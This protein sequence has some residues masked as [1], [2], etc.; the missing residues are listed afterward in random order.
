MR[1]ILESEFEVNASQPGSIMRANCVASKL[2]GVYSRRV[3]QAY[4]KESIGGF[5]FRAVNDSNTSLEIDPTKID[6]KSAGG[7]TPE[8]QLKRNQDA[9]LAQAQEIFTRISSADMVKAMPREM[10][11]IAYFTAEYARQ[12]APDRI[13]PLV[14]GFVMLRIFNPSLLTPEAY[15]LLPNGLV[16]GPAARRNLT[17]ITKLLQNLSNNVEFGSKE[18]FMVPM[19]VFIERNRDRMTQYL[20][21]LARDPLTDDAAAA[22]RDCKSPPDKV[23]DA[24][25]LRLSD[26]QSIHQYFHQHADKLRDKI[27]AS[28]SANEFKRLLLALGAPSTKQAPKKAAAPA[29]GAASSSDANNGGGGGGDESCGV[30][31]VVLKAGELVR[32]DHA[33]R[34]GQFYFVLTPQLLYYFRARTDATPHRAVPLDDVAVVDL[35]D[36]GASASFTLTTTGKSHKLTAENGA[37]T[38]AWADAIND[39]VRKYS[40]R[41]A[42]LAPHVAIDPEAACATKGDVARAMLL[43]QRMTAM[44]EGLRVAWFGRLAGAESQ[45]RRPWFV[46]ECS[47]FGARWIVKHSYSEIADLLAALG[48]LFPRLAL[49][50]LPRIADGDAMSELI[51]KGKKIT[52]A[53]SETTQQLNIAITDANEPNEDLVYLIKFV[54]ATLDELRT[55]E[56]T[57]QSD[58]L[59]AF[60]DISSPLRAAESGNLSQLQFLVDNAANFNVRSD[61]GRAPM[62]IAVLK[63]RRDAVE[64]LALEAKADVNIADSGGNSPLHLAIY[65]NNPEIVALLLA[66]GARLNAFNVLE[67]S[68]LM[69]ACEGG[70]ES[71]VVRLLARGAKVNAADSRGQTPLHL[72]IKASSSSIAKL[73]LEHGAD[74]SPADKNGMTPLA[75]ATE[76]KLLD[77]AA[78]LVESG[79]CAPN[80]ADSKGRTAVHTAASRGQTRVLELL[81]QAKQPA[82]NF[83]ARDA[84]GNTPLHLA[85]AG[86]HEESLDVL[87]RSF[88]VDLDAVNNAGLTPLH[89]AAKRNAVAI[90]HKLV[91]AGASLDTVAPD[92]RTPLHAAALAGA[93]EVV[94]ALCRFDATAAPVA[95]DGKKRTPLHCAAFLG[96]VE[97]TRALAA[98]CAETI[99]MRD[100]QGNTPLMLACWAKRVD[101]ARLLVSLGANV[102][103]TDLSEGQTVLHICA[104]SGSVEL[105]TELLAVKDANMNAPRK[106][107]GFTPLHFACALEQEATVR[108]L[109]KAKADINVQDARKNTPLHIAV[110]KQ[111][112]RIALLLAANGAF[113]LTQNADGKTPVALCKPRFKVALE[114][115]AQRYANRKPGRPAAGTVVDEPLSPRSN[116]VTSDVTAAFGF[117]D[118]S[119]SSPAPAAAATVLP[120]VSAA[121]AREKSTRAV[122]TTPSVAAVAIDDL[123]ESMRDTPPLASTASS[124][125]RASP[126]L[127]TSSEGESKVETPRNAPVI[128]RIAKLPCTLVG[129]SGDERTVECD[130]SGV[131]TIGDLCS[132]IRAAFALDEATSWHLAYVDNDGDEVILPELDADGLTEVTEFAKQLKVHTD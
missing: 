63:Q 16:P 47:A 80:V 61:T 116:T 13:V 130:F 83:G 111:F 69:A 131:E 76:H 132:K 14:G 77:I 85:V 51:N 94:T 35:A 74:A 115:A 32:V 15:G 108:A 58:P 66:V 121:A 42:K 127:V 119:P 90:A 87:F 8:Q 21:E 125:T 17:L 123:I 57:G 73:L 78:Q 6:K 53:A 38:R 75:L 1:S 129:A 27:A 100:E 71:S 45:Q 102:A 117:A 112:M 128:R 60:W 4:L 62:H 41:H 5:V 3:G 48:K 107:D 44:N 106:S 10:R 81:G 23:I 104:G 34:H 33:V 79:A 9:L 2:S 92:G 88:G 126:E 26:V 103:A 99:E 56:L 86:G 46:C 49:P 109:L 24:T 114:E 118:T 11:A 95:R 68:P 65:R 43:T 18:Q 110:S 25:E 64:F 12:Y 30:V 70:H 72:A 19:N 52:G 105:L 20:T 29:G 82:V 122:P 98:A 55:N 67:Q 22:Y 40:A 59:F 37:A 89:L 120:G 113:M 124:A 50:T 54:R 36:E 91:S 84:D 93:T 101:V 28:P 96:Y 39:A 97:T 7:V 31:G